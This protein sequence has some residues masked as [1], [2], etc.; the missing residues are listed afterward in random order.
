LD[1]QILRI[2][3]FRIFANFRNTGMYRKNCDV[4]NCIPRQQKERDAP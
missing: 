3:I 4:Q 1:R 2:K